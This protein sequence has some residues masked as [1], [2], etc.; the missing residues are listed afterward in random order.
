MAEERGRLPPSSIS[1]FRYHNIRPESDVC[2][3]LCGVL[4]TFVTNRNMT[5]CCLV[6][7]ILVDLLALAY[8]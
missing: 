3:V 7:S 2:T 5:I 8:R 6:S 1:A 4:G